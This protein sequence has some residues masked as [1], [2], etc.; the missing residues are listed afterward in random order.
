M[1]KIYVDPTSTSPSELGTMA[2]PY[3]TIDQAFI[4]IFNYWPKADN[5]VKVVVKEATTNKV[6]FQ[7]RP[8][9]IN[10]K[11]NVEITTYKA[12]GT[13]PGDQ[14][15][16]QVT[17]TETYAADPTT[18]FSLMTGK[19]YDYAGTGSEL[20]GNAT[21]KAA[22]DT[23][24]YTFIILQSHFKIDGL[25]IDN[26]LKL[27]DDDFAIIHPISNLLPRTLT[28]DNC[29]F[30][31]YGT[32][33]YTT[34][35]IGF[36]STSVTI[37]TPRLVG[38]F[39]FLVS[40]S[41][42]TTEV[43]T[44]EV[45]IDKLN[46][47][48]ARSVLFKYGGIYMTGTQNFTIT[49]SYIGSYGFMFD[50]K[51]LTRADSPLNCQ[52][53]DGVKQIIRLES[54]TYDMLT[55]YTGTP[56]HGFIC[57]FLEWYPRK[58]MEVFFINNTMKNIAKSFYRV[59][60]LDVNSAAVTVENN[61]FKDTT[62]SVDI[63][64]IDTTKDVII[65]N[66]T[67]QNISSTSQNIIVIA[68][69][70]NVLI[71]D[72]TMNGANPEQVSSSII[73]LNMADNAIAILRDIKFTNNI[74]LGTKA[75]VS[76]QLLSIFD[77]TNSSFAG[78]Q[79]MQ[80][81]NY[82][83]IQLATKISIT[84]TNFTGITYQNVDDSGAYLIYVASEQSNA[85]AEDSFIERIKFTNIKTNAISFG[86]FT[87]AV[88]GGAG[89]LYIKDVDFENSIFSSPDS[90]ISTKKFSYEG[91]SKMIITEARFTDLEFTTFGNLIHLT[92]N[93]I[94]PFEIT[95][96]TFNR[97][98]G[99]GIL[100][101]PQDIFN[102]SMP[103]TLDIVNCTFT[104][105]T[106]WVAGFV[107]V[108]ENSVVH[109]NI[110]TFTNTASGGSGSV[111]LANYKEN[112]VTIRDS[113]FTNNYAILGGV[114]YSQ[115]SSVITCINCR[116]NNNIAIRGGVAFLNSNGR[117]DLQQSDLTLNQ[118]LNAPSLYISAC[119][120]EFSVVSSSDIY[121]NN[122]ITMEQLLARSAARTDHIIDAYIQEVQDNRIFYE[123]S[124][125]GSKKS[126][127]SMIKGKLRVNE[128]TRI[129][130][131]I[132][133]LGTFESEIEII[134]T[135]F[136]NV[137]LSSG[138]IIFHLLSSTFTYTNSTMNSIDCPEQDEAMFQVR[139][140]STFKTQGK[141]A[142]INNTNCQFAF[143][144]YS[145][146]QI[147]DITFDTANL[148][149]AHIDSIESDLEFKETT[150]R[151]VNTSATALMAIEN[152]GSLV[153][154]SAHFL[155]SNKF[156]FSVTGSTL[157]FFNTTFQNDLG[158]NIR[159]AIF[160]ECNVNINNSTFQ[161]LSYND[162]GGAI[163]TLNSQ[164]NLLGG[165]FYNNSAPKGGA[166]AFRCEEGNT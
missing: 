126:A 34:T 138:H 48:G 26:V 64:Q 134:D 101:E 31:N 105:N 44:G 78:D 141:R 99:A 140:E 32:A 84:D 46:F 18:R 95:Q 21:E 156:Y 16:L 59:L 123:K 159:A 28:I 15:N 56:H 36:S 148:L 121:L 88:T 149:E 132:D 41:D 69:S 71:E 53:D 118:A 111:V 100:L 128:N 85:A 113:N 76:Q 39:V 23:Q 74:F 142:L 30:V 130:N 12:D 9:V 75:I 8:L 33:M 77:L 125:S 63:S 66:N 166:V 129:F 117:I 70:S 158:Q 155:S 133:F 92:H 124:V 146:A 162:L 79:I 89:H 68:S 108:F 43:V 22:I 7:E 54:N 65:K 104:D 3:K 163:D 61:L 136:E 98:Y 29:H 114:F 157:T 152:S 10:R 151:N 90:L 38:G 52:P 87:D 82:I 42:P 50:A 112:S 1:D 119:Q 11:D 86:G 144:L 120:A 145:T 110:S 55:E 45:V 49:N 131:Q 47:S 135:L 51:Q 25:K 93:A 164:V 161:H 137:T 80:N 106:P 122:V 147:Y 154:T 165:L 107:N 4:E 109:I 97:V 160:E 143:L 102:T 73:N 116:F 35:S 40:C 6:Y 37:E 150:L 17:N 57:S 153:T 91:A 72:F 24:W 96:V 139:L 19:T 27:E 62:G 67:F 20:V 58:D 103:L 60:L 13:V 83:D 115:F 94:Q 2:H 14:A 127:I 81:T 5:P